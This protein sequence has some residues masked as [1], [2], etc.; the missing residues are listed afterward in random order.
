MTRSKKLAIAAL[1]LLAIG[2]ISKPDRGGVG[3]CARIFAMPDLHQFH[4]SHRPFLMWELFESPKFRF[5]I[6]P[7]DFSRL[8]AALKLNGY[9]AWTK[10][11]VSYGSVSH[12]EEPDED[13]VYC[14]SKRGGYSYTW[15]YSAKESRIYAI[16][17][18]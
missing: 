12:G 10:G 6:S 7:S 4:L 16:Q 11:G 13:Y 15:S 18:P 5:M 9:P 2:Y 8:D 1:I 14:Q 17:F 3:R